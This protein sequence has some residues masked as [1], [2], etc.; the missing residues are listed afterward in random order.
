MFVEVSSVLEECMESV[1]QCEEL[2][3]L[4]QYRKDLSQLDHNG[5]FLDQ[6]GLFSNCFILFF[7]LYSNCTSFLQHC[8]FSERS[9][10]EE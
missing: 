3:T 7:I 9:N 8:T 2:K 10:R 5:K 1:S 4:L 6:L